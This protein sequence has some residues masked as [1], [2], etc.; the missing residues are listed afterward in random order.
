MSDERK[1]V[2]KKHAAY[3][4]AAGTA[5][6]VFLWALAAWRSWP[7][8]VTVLLLGSAAVLSLGVLLYWQRRARRAA[9]RL[10]RDAVERHALETAVQEQRRLAAALREIGVALSATLDF[11]Q[12][13]DSLL[14]QIARVLPYDTANVMLVVDDAIQIVCTRGYEQRRPY[15]DHFAIAEVPSLQEM[16]RTKEPLII[17]DTAVAAHWVKAE[18]SPHVRSWAGAPITVRGQ[19]VAFLALNNSKPN[20]YRPED[21]VRLEAFAGQAAIAIQNARLYDQL[22][23]RVNELT[24]MNTISQVVS[25]TLDLQETLTIITDHT[26]R[27]LGVDAT[28]VALVDKEKNDL[29]F[30]AASGQASDFVLGKRIDMGQGVVGWVAQ[31][32]EAVLIRDALQDRRY[33]P[34]FDQ[35]SGFQARSI[36]CVPL[37]S[38]GL[39]I[40]VVEAINKEGGPF[41]DEDLRLLTLLAGPAATAI[42]NAQLYEQA[43]QEISRRAQVE[44]DL[45]A[46]RALLARRVEERTADLS[47]ANAELARAA[48][49]KDEFLASISHELR[50]PLNAILGISEALQE[51]VYGDLNEKQLAS[52]VS[53][54][55]SGRHLLSLINDILDLSK[56]EAGKLDLEIRPMSVAAVCQASLRLVRQN[57]LKKKLSLHEEI[58]PAVQTIQADERRVKQILVNLLSNAVKFTPAGGEIGLEVV[59]DKDAR[60]ARFTVW[61]TGI[62]ISQANLGRLFRPFVQLDSSLSRE[63]AGTGLGLSLAYRMVELHGGSVSVESALGKGSRFTV[64]LPWQEPGQ[65]VDPQREA[66]LVA[67]DAPHLAGLRRAL[68]VASAAALTAQLIRYLGELGLETSTSA[69]AQGAWEKALVEQPD[70][71]LLDTALADWS[72]WDVLQQLKSEPP[73]R[74]IP[75]LL[76]VDEE[77]R[78]TAVSPEAIL[79]KPPKRQDV[80]AA[81]RKVLIQRIETQRTTILDANRPRSRDHSPLILLAEDN[82][83]NIQMFT[84]YLQTQQYRLLVA[85]TGHE[86]VRLAREAVPDL[87]LMD[88]QL[89]EMSG[90]DAIRAIRADSRTAQIPI[91][92][93]T[94]LAMPNDHEACLRAGANA[95]ISKPVRLKALS[96][97]IERYLG[98]GAQSFSQNEAEFT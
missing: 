13:L 41:Q 87:V 86:A 60:L 37:Q 35:Q 39:T 6:A 47:A 26:T 29:W 16:T 76:L 97:L 58:D 77:E 91:I 38:K 62:G 4:V 75:V 83:T 63:Y 2:E 33:F 49:L 12:L 78:E 90:L 36:L 7:D 42:E 20:F 67:A 53:I 45:E 48:R 72:G 34:D 57:A 51:E 71:I 46:E 23:R 22:Q 50:T 54:E 31:H 30:A 44:A 1:L 61:D 74:R 85:R 64:L 21:A 19:I 84:D 5:T 11:D 94:A 3:L 93:V 28:S 98:D 82:P 95:Y 59:G 81:L 10:S 43:Q 24:T 80:H 88:I 18:D 9:E 14:D 40:G 79:T 96:E 52:L 25:S 32:G 27:L 73:T 65:G 56:A 69:L 8:V 15:A 17:A 66:E 55:E 68:L 92:A 70:V 89:P